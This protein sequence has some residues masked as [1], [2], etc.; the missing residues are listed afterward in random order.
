MVDH[1]VGVVAVTGGLGL[2]LLDDRYIRIPIRCTGACTT[3]GP[4]T[5]SG[6][7]ISSR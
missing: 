6:T 5:G 2:A 4:F 3:T 7:R 1:C